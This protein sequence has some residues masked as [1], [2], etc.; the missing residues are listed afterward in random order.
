[1]TTYVIAQGAGQDLYDRAKKELGY[2]G[3][4]GEFLATFKGEKGEDGAAGA[5]GDTGERGTDGLHAALPIYR[6]RP[7]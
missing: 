7:Y 1:M 2:T 3:T 5:K 4:F 6:P